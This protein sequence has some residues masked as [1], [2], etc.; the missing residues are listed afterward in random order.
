MEIEKRPRCSHL[1]RVK[2]KIFRDFILGNL[3]CLRLVLTGIMTV[4]NWL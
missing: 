1:Q 3:T 4:H 2:G